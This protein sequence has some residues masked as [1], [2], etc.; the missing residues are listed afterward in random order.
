MLSSATGV[1][2]SGDGSVSTTQDE[3]EVS[4]LWEVSFCRTGITDF[5]TSLI[6]AQFVCF[7]VKV[8]L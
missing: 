7:D 6:L 3:I 1:I 5:Y 8:L 2:L 4:Q